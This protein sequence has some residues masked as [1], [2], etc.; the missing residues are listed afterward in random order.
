MQG[1]HGGKGAK[2]DVA[3]YEG[4]R[5][6]SGHGG[7][8]QDRLQPHQYQ[9]QHQ[10][11]QP[12]QEPQVEG[13]RDVDDLSDLMPVRNERPVGRRADPMRPGKFISV[14]APAYEGSGDGE[15]V[16]ESPEGR[17]IANGRSRC[18]A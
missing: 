5:G 14:S 2:H 17:H 7:Y 3:E 9:Q 1:E 10:S 18:N 13:L 4:E 11:R 12:T 16:V 8:E 6:R 15:G